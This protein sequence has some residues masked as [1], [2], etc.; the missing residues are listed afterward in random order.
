MTDTQL[1]DLLAAIAD[2]RTGGTYWG[3]RPNLPLAPYTLIRVSDERLREKLAV[4]L[5]G[6]RTLL[7]WSTK[8]R[9]ASGSEHHVFGDCDP[10][11]L[12]SGAADVIVDA[13][14]ELT[15]IAAL[16]AVPVRCVGEGAF[17]PLGGSAA[18]EA[19]RQVFRSTFIDHVTYLDPFS[20]TPIS[21]S[22]VVD[23]SRF[24]R[25]LIDGNRN[26][27]A[28]FGFAFW[29]RPTVAPLLWAGAGEV[30]FVSQPSEVH[31]GASVAIW[32]SRVPPSA[33]QQ[34][35]AKRANCIEVEDGFI[36]SVGLGANCVPPLSI[37]VD[38]LGAH[39]DPGKPSELELLLESGEFGPELLERAQR[40]RELIIVSG[41]SKYASGAGHGPARRRV[42]GRKHIL[43]PG[44]VEDD[45]SML[46]GGTAVKTNLE[47]LRRT[48]KQEPDAYILYKPHPDV[49]A[50]HRIGA[51]PD[52]A[53]LALANEVVRDSA[54]S[55]LI[56]MVDE[57]HVTTSLAGFE[58]LLRGKP[59][60]THGV[61]FYAGW[62]LTRDLG[63]VPG[64]RTKR[65]S[66]N[67]LVAA[68]LLLYPRY[69]DP[70]TGLPCPP[71]VLI[72]RLS[73]TTSLPRT[74]A[75]VRLRRFQGQLKR[76]LSLRSRR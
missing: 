54:I 25:N 12:L 33:L 50:G 26:I 14:D 21:L 46:T 10:W 13:D 48:R 27:R 63:P 15:V 75:V 72:R 57:L 66:L 9:R 7:L 52:G 22:Q 68:V 28:A 43:I 6:D 8:S 34:L 67:E 62:G 11:H 58:A 3:A 18:P 39:F 2:S 44:Q 53:V 65:R 74:G 40:L 19:L 37:V 59:V 20:E 35:E 5:S 1:D 55:P 49:E 4:E 32:R 70:E 51:I 71:E 60:T 41:V 31:E 23:I 29:K 30:P 56:D 45:R 17:Q 38:R 64:R 61:P 16:S 42:A 73:Q 76:V 69:L 36:R 24:W 47:L